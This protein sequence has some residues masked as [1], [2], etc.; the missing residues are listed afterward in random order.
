M[1]LDQQKERT[2]DARKNVADK[3]RQSVNNRQAVN[4]SESELRQKRNEMQVQ[5]HQLKE[6]QLMAKQSKQQEK[7]AQVQLNEEKGRMR[8]QKRLNREA[9]ANE[10]NP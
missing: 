2:L 8:D 4:A 7:A 9:K 3:H 6:Q 10:L 1:R 5:K